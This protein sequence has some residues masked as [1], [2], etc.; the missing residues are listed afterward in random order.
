MVLPE[1]F[2]PVNLD[3]AAARQ[4]A[5]A[6]R[7]VEPERAGRDRLDLD[8]LLVL[9]EPHDGA[10]AEAAL[11]L[12]DRRFQ[13]LLFIHLS[14][15]DKAQRGIRHVDSPLFHSPTGPA[16]GALG[17]HPHPACRSAGGDGSVRGEGAS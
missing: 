17:S 12:R 9:A 11:D 5:D 16:N 3:D 6:E 4:P 2:G 7:D 13:R 15:F 1:R 14:S 8:G 10:F